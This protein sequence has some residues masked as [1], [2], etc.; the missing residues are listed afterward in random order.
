MPRAVA[1]ITAAMKST[2]MVKSYSIILRAKNRLLRINLFFNL[3]TNCRASGSAITHLSSFLR[4]KCGDSAV[5]ILVAD[6]VYR[7]DEELMRDA[8]IQNNQSYYVVYAD[9]TPSYTESLTNPP[10]YHDRRTS[11]EGQRH[12]PDYDDVEV[13]GYLR[14]AYFEELVYYPTIP[15]LSKTIFLKLSF[16]RKVGI[17]LTNHCTDHADNFRHELYMKAGYK[18]Q[19]V[20]DSQGTIHTTDD[21]IWS[22]A[23]EHN[24]V[25]TVV[26][27]NSG[28]SLTA[29]P[30]RQA[31]TTPPPVLSNTMRPALTGSLGH[32]IR[33]ISSSTTRSMHRVTSRNSTSTIEQPAPLLVK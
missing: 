4:K 24:G 25:Y 3:Y 30:Q 6:T 9:Y 19:G 26:K 18:A 23:I 27:E 2:A 10:M 14:P 12:L 28:Y 11:E 5:G 31:I 22:N 33:R 17:T 1:P 13:T 16:G 32:G 29:A 21:I 7:N 15:L 8:T 20:L